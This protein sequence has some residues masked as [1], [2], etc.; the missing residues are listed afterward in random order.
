MDAETAGLKAQID[1]LRGS[2]RLEEDKGKA[3]TERSGR[4]TGAKEQEQ[5][6]NRLNQTVMEVY[7]E[8]FSETDN[9]LSTLQMAAGS[10][11]CNTNSIIK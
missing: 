8:I 10:Q 3:L 7:R 9:S 1:S 6:L 11:T 2:I 4:N 5:T